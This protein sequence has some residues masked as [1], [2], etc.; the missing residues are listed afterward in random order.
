MINR[1][2]PGEFLR[3]ADSEKKSL[4]LQLRE[5]YDM[6]RI[7]FLLQ[8][9]TKKYT[10]TVKRLELPILR[11]GNN[12]K[13]SQF[14]DELEEQFQRTMGGGDLLEKNQ[15]ELELPKPLP[16]PVKDL[17]DLMSTNGVK[18]ESFPKPE[19]IDERA[20]FFSQMGEEMS[21]MLITFANV[22]SGDDLARKLRKIADQI[23]GENVTV[24]SRLRIEEILPIHND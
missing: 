15:L 24:M 7:L 9:K 1:L 20:I 11:R 3:L 18:S 22:F 16:V 23:E 17:Q 21:G 14:P 19:T 8:I 5:L 10:D 2:Q 4:L 6:P 12:Y 13:P